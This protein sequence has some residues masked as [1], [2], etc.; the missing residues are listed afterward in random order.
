M[1]SDTTEVD[2]DSVLHNKCSITVLEDSFTAEEDV[3]CIS[4]LNGS[5]LHSNS[6]SNISDDSVVFVEAIFILIF[7]LCIGTLLFFLSS[8]RQFC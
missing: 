8:W 2:N 6:V 1:E 4:V 3:L 5:A 7:Y